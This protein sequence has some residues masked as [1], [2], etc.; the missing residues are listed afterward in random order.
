VEGMANIL[1]VDAWPKGPSKKAITRTKFSKW[2]LCTTLLMFMLQALL[3]GRVPSHREMWKV[4]AIPCKSD[5]CRIHSELWTDDWCIS[6]HELKYTLVYY[7]CDKIELPLPCFATSLVLDC[8]E[9][10]PPVNKEIAMLLYFRS[11]P[12]GMVIKADTDTVFEPYRLEE[13]ISSLLEDNPRGLYAGSCIT[14]CE[15][16]GDQRN[17]FF[18]SSINY[19]SGFFYLVTTKLL[20]RIPE[21]R[22]VPLT[23]ISSGEKCRSSDLSVGSILSMKCSPLKN[24]TKPPPPLGQT[25]RFTE[26]GK[27]EVLRGN[28]CNAKDTPGGYLGN[29]IVPSISDFSNDDY[30]S[31]I[32]IHPLKRPFQFQYVLARLTQPKRCQAFFGVLSKTGDFGGRQAVRLTWGRV[33]RLLGMQLKFYVGSGE[34]AKL[35]LELEPDV[36]PVQVV[37]SDE[38]VFLKSLQVIADG[39]RSECDF[40]FMTDTTTYVRPFVLKKTLDQILNISGDQY[41]GKSES[42]FSMIAHEERSFIVETQSFFDKIYQRLAYLHFYGISSDLARIVAARGPKSPTQPPFRENATMRIIIDHKKG[43]EAVSY[44]SVLPFGVEQCDSK[45]IAA[46]HPDQM[47]R[48]NNSWK[49]FGNE[50]EEGGICSILQECRNRSRQSLR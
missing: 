29:Q 12:N 36:V 8:E 28:V 43:R 39:A 3:I 25:S 46:I 24:P 11:K 26:T 14:S 48:D 19:A 30:E 23:N 32:A 50:F 34:L 41:F 44:Q 38:L 6:L 49:F 31:C 47:C 18:E 20:Q 5:T 16:T 7:S 1:R 40:I 15:C 45:S 37:E 27:R 33:A 17:C 4:I 35:L 13:T 21:S 42:K 22:F 2:F 10:F 9:D